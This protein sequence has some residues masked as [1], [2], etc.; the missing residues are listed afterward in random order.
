MLTISNE[1]IRSDFIEV[2]KIIKHLRVSKKLKSSNVYTGILSRPAVSRFEKGLS[3]TTSEKFFKILDNLN[4]SLDEFYFIY[5]DYVQ[6][7]TLFFLRRYSNFFNKN[8]LEGLHNLQIS[9]LQKYNLSGKIKYLHYSTLCSLTIS[10]V[11]NSPTNTE[12]LN[13]LKNYL[14]ECEEWTYYEVVLF[15]NSLDFFS[16]DLILLLYKR[17]KD[18][19][20]YFSELKKYMTTATYL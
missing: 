6:E 11:S 5:N 19:L 14:L 13:I 15:T 17:T 7:D 10:S 1:N 4:V 20:K 16:E 3:D 2:G 9:A 18:K 12:D 8:D